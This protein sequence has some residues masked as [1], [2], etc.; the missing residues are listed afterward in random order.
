[1]ENSF[2]MMVHIMKG[3]FPTIKLMEMELFFINRTVLPT[4]ENGST[5]SFKDMDNFLIKSHKFYQNPLTT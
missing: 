4:K 1:M 2:I 5:N 3:T